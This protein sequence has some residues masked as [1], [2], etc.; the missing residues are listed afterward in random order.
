M[1]K[2][3]KS[4]GFQLKSGNKPTFNEMRG[5]NPGT[6]FKP[7]ESKD[8]G[9]YYKSPYKQEETTT[10]SPEDEESTTPEQQGSEPTTEKEKQEPDKPGTKAWKILANTL[11]G[12]FD[13]VY[14][15]KTKRPKINWGKKEKAEDT[16]TIEEKMDDLL[17][18]K[19]DSD[20]KFRKN[21]KI[22]ITP[23]EP[24][25]YSSYNKSQMSD[26]RKRLKSEGTWDPENDPK[27]AE[28][29]NRINELYGSSKR[30]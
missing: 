4:T 19:K 18:G 24:A 15:T 13:H 20:R 27:S 10:P 7:M 9:L 14:G 17:G 2:F 6:V 5:M 12:G 1:P 16:R 22:E 25:D 29:Q 26:E 11:I 30:Y 21:P 8:T 28:I 23:T 3:N